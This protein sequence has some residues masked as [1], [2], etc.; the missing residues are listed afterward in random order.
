M[1]ATMLM[2]LVILVL[3]TPAL[4]IHTIV[5]SKLMKHETEWSMVR[6]SKKKVMTFLEGFMMLGWLV[7]YWSIGNILSTDRQGSDGMEHRQSLVEEYLKCTGVIG[8]C[9]MASLAGF[10]AVSSVWQT[11]G[12]KERPV[13]LTCC[14]ACISL[15]CITPLGVLKKDNLPKEIVDIIQLS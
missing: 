15:G 9:L 12:H 5:S 1:R 6:S 14:K 2:L 7:G 13:C 10:A 11:F 4:E 3:L 8:I